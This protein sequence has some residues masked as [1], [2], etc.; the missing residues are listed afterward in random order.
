MSDQ[1]DTPSPKRAARQKDGFMA[2][3]IVSLQKPPPQPEFDV[4]WFYEDE[5]FFAE[6]MDGFDI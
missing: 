3:N 1:D 6:H 2:D 5:E 4:D